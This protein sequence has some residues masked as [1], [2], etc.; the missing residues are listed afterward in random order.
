MPQDEILDA[1]LLQANAK[2]LKQINPVWPLAAVPVASPSVQLQCFV[3]PV[4][5][6]LVIQT[7]GKGFAVPAAAFGKGELHER[8]GPARDS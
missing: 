7:A 5:D 3:E 8:L 4:K 1:L 6:S 2:V